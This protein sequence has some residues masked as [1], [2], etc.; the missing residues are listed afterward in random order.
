MGIE[1]NCI[2]PIRKLNEAGKTKKI[3]SSSKKIEF[4]L[5]R[6]TDHKVFRKE[7]LLFKISFLISINKII[8]N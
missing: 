6:F 7:T 4:D 5:A 2:F 3:L 1:K 8:T